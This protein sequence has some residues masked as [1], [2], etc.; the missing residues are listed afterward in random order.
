MKIGISSMKVKDESSD[1]SDN[2]YHSY[3]YDRAWENERIQL[4]TNTWT[5]ITHHWQSFTT[6]R[7]L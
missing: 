5:N 6:Q 1:E 3:D 2:E 4:R 7:I